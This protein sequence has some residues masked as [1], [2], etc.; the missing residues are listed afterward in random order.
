MLH[1]ETADLDRYYMRR[2]SPEE[3]AR[4]TPHVALCERCASYLKETDIILG[5]L[6]QYAASVSRAATDGS[7]SHTL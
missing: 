7:V 3:S 2:C 6:R 5:V 1:P 4:I